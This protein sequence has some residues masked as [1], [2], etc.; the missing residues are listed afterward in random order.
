[1]GV[2]LGGS[3]RRTEFF[4]SSKKANRNLE[5]KSGRFA[6]MTAADMRAMFFIYLALIVAGLLGFTLIGLLER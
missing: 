4:P 6:G 2:D 5:E 3:V 1:L